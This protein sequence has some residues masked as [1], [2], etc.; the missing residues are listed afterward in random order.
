MENRSFNSDS[1][2]YLAELNKK[3]Q[4]E[5]LLL[6][7][8]KLIGWFK[9]VYEGEIKK[10]I[11]SDYS[12]RYVWIKVPRRYRVYGHKERDIRELLQTE[13]R[14]LGFNIDIDINHWCCPLY[15]FCDD[16]YKIKFSW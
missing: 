8:G 2:K 7:C 5:Q 10:A 16:K 14:S 13:F 15:P 12:S 9:L 1:A 4:R 11:D 3:S 6:D